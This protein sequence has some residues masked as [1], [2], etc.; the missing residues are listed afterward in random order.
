[1]LMLIL[2]DGEEEAEW[3]VVLPVDALYSWYGN[4]D[5]L[6]LAGTSLH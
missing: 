1:M 4:L 6:L 2:T 3:W 5:Y